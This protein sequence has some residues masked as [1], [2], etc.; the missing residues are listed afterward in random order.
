MLQQGF[1]QGYNLLHG[2]ASIAPF[3]VT[4]FENTM[5]VSLGFVLLCVQVFIASFLFVVLM[6]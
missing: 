4:E 3:W 5:S 1:C 2:W 6:G